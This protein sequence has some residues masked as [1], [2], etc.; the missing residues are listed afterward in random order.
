MDVTT[1][2]EMY[3]TIKDLRKNLGEMAAERNYYKSQYE[4]L[5]AEYHFLEEKY[6]D[7]LDDVQLNEMRVFN[8]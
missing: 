1:F 3:G 6:Y 4:Q 2:D 5:E 8:I 7:L